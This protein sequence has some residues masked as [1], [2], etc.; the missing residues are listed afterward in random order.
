MAPAVSGT[1][2]D[3]PSVVVVGSLNL[4]VVVRTP[5]HPR[6]GETVLGHHHAEYPGGKGANQAV[7]AARLGARTAMLGRVGEDAAADRLRTSLAEAGVDLTAVRATPGV[8]TGAAFITV[9]DT[10]ENTIVVS[11]GANARLSA[12]D[13]DD[14]HDLLAAAD[15]CL[16]QLEVA[17]EV[18]AQAVRSAG[19]R[20]VLNP[21]P[22]RELTREVLAG[23]DVLVPNEGELAVLAGRTETPSD[24]DE[25]AGLARSLAVPTVVVTLGA[26]G[27]LVI[28]DDRV[29]HLP[30]PE[31]EVVDTTA[32]G[33]T[34]CGA[35]AAAL[36]RGDDVVTAARWAVAAAALSVQRA[37]A[38]PSIPSRDEMEEAH[39]AT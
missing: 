13:V 5:S 28:T 31:V 35:L 36:V 4:D 3:H 1:D 34:F 39:H 26:R 22:A 8:R 29:D 21:A 38:Q 2:G 23:V 24:P 32:A 20:V 7:A 37:G 19:G 25:L 27:A 12:A 6:P 18:V 14:Q 15:V 17:D 33:D 16:L 10:G 30:A 9:D 11:P